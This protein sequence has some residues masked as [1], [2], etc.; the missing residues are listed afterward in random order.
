MKDV[1]LDEMMDL[2][3]EEMIETSGGGNGAKTAGYLVGQSIAFTLGG[4][5]GMAIYQ[6]N[7]FFK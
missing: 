2:S 1:Y 7:Y 6:Y 5:I 4:P 3:L